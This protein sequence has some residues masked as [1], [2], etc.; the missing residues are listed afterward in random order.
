METSFSWY[1][2]LKILCNKCYLL[3]FEISLLTNIMKLR[4][5][6]YLLEG[7]ITH[8]KEI[9]PPHIKCLNLIHY[10]TIFIMKNLIDLKSFE[11]FQKD[12]TYVNSII[13]S[14]YKVYKNKYV[15]V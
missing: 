14:R 5:S 12:T 6:P 2:F 9:N 7:S 1:F 10:A 3:N 8:K 4:N 15:D 13:F 11:N